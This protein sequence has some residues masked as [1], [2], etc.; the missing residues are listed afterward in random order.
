MKY[1]YYNIENS[2][3]KSN[4]VIRTFS[5][6]FNLSFDEIMNE[7]VNIMND[8]KESSPYEISVFEEF[9]K[10]RNMN[11][12]DY[13]NDIKVKDLELDNGT[14]SIFCYDKKDFY[15]MVSIIDNTVYDKSDECLNLYTIKVYKLNK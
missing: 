8:L 13:G 9:M 5:K 1:V 7:L 6:I 14:Y 4:C 3:G 15:H 12:I 11:S 10:R 2:E